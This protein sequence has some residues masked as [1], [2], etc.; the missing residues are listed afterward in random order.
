M[1]PHGGR[2]R[3]SGNRKPRFNRRLRALRRGVGSGAKRI[4]TA[5]LCSA[6]AAL[7]QLSYSPIGCVQSY[8]TVRL[9][10]G[11]DRQLARYDL[12]FNLLQSS[13]RC[14]QPVSLQPPFS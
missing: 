2:T 8:K 11:S 14:R 5:D 9:R 10:T 4:R 12:S 3:R 13:P 7:C 1:Y 6:I